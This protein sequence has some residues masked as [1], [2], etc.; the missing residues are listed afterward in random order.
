MPT[1]AERQ[2]RDPPNEKEHIVEQ[3][4]PKRSY[5]L[6]VGVDIA[7]REFTAA[8]LVAGTKPTHASQPYTQTAAGFEGFQA[9]LQ[10]SGVVPSDILV[11]MEATG[12]Y[13][14]ALANSLYQAGYAVSVINPAQAQNARQGT[15]ETS[16]E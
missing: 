1:E 13:W 3:K 15:T 8:S 10:E 7:A 11:V 5:H 14:V 9:R 12:R 6:F 16:Q 2:Q 4:V